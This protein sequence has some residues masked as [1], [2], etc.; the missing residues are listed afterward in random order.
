MM[1]WSPESRLAFASIVAP[2]AAPV[3]FT[4]TVFVAGT[5]AQTHPFYDWGIPLV[6]MIV[7]VPIAYLNAVVVAL[8]VWAIWDR[9]SLTRSH[10][11]LTVGASLSGAITMTVVLDKDIVT[12]LAGAVIGFLTALLFWTIALRN[13]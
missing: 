11:P 9:S 10:W 13:P 2:P 1:R 5:V 7:G 4:L 3:L 6:W 12:A 8:P